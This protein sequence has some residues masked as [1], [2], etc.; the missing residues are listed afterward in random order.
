[1]TSCPSPDTAD[2]MPD[3]VPYA[4]FNTA[5]TGFKEAVRARVDPFALPV[6]AVLDQWRKQWKQ[7][8]R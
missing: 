2:V 6:V 5:W 7:K 4:E 1:M 8:S 3:D